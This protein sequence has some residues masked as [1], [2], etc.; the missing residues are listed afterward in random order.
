MI[1]P[2]GSTL[3]VGETMG[4]RYTAFTIADDGSLGDRR[5]WADV[6]GYAP[7]GC[8]LDADGGIW[9]ADALGARVVRVVEGGEITDTHRHRRRDLRLCRSVATTAAPCSC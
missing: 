5:L 9:F 2:D 6:E 4:A 7:D 3:I 1:T 8:T